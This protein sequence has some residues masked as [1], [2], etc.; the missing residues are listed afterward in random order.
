MKGIGE[1]MKLSE[2]REELKVIKKWKND[3]SKCTYP[4]NHLIYIRSEAIRKQSYRN[5]SIVSYGDMC[6]LEMR[7]NNLISMIN[8]EEE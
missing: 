1:N 8:G 3:V 4:L 5:I 6:D 2:L 7:C